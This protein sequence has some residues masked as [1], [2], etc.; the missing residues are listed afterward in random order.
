[1]ANQSGRQPPC[2]QLPYV[3][4]GT[5]R[6]PSGASDEQAR[7]LTIELTVSLPDGRIVDVASTIP[8]PGYT[9]LLQGLLSGLQLNQVEEA[10]R[11]LEEHLCGPLLKPTIAALQKAASASANSAAAVREAA[12]PAT[13]PGS[14]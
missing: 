3:A 12:P 9:A 14:R 7:I 4:V 5:A 8:L 10:A 13:S 1:M 11:Q 6:L 2:A